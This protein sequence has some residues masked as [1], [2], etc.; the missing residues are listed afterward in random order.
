MQ[1]VKCPVCQ[2]NG[3]VSNG[4]YT[5]TSTDEEGNLLWTSASTASEVCRSCDGKGYIIVEKMRK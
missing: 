1:A 2:G 3:Q 4:F 5:T